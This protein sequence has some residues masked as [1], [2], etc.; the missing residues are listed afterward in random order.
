MGSFASKPNVQKT[1]NGM[2]V[3]RNVPTNSVPSVVPPPVVSA[4]APPAPPAPFTPSNST[5]VGGRRKT[6]KTRKSEKKAKRS[7]RK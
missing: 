2:N 5:S 3:R 6:R 4:P 7:N 1:N